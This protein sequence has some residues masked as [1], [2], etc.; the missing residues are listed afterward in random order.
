MPIRFENAPLAEIVAQVQWQQSGGFRVPEPGELILAPSSG[1]APRLE[2]F[3]LRFGTALHALGFT[4]AERLA[5]IGFP[6]LPFQPVYRYR[7]PSAIS[8]LFQI[9]PGIFSAHAV[10]PY[11]SW[12]SFAPNVESGLKALVGAQGEDEA[13]GALTVKLRYIDAFGPDLAGGTDFAA[14]ISDVLG[15][16]LHLPKAFARIK[17]LQA[18]LRPHVQFRVAVEP[19]MQLHFILTEGMMNGAAAA[20]MDTAIVQEELISPNV[21]Q[22]MSAL[23]RSRAKIH[24]LFIALTEPIHDRMKPVEA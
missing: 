14:F 11:K 16:R 15:F 17:A 23:T 2:A 10:P 8:P 9:G 19:K 21:D 22:V 20:V 4:Q 13:L 1:V 3:F 24:D 7:Q 5:P 12:E 6:T 18:E